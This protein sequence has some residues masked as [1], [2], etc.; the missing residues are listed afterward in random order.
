MIDVAP[1]NG[2]H[3]VPEAEEAR[4]DESDENADQEEPAVGG[5]RDEQNGYHSD[6]DGQAGG[7]LQAKSK[8]AARFG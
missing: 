7:A 6:G 4:D 8:P 5:Q 3:L 1:F 2:M